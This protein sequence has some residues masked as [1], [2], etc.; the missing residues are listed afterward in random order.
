LP[1]E[2]AAKKRFELRFEG[3]CGH[4]RFLFAFT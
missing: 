4:V 2:M 3:S 1:V